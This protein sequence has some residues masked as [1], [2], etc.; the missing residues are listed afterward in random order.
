[1]QNTFTARYGVIKVQMGCFE[2]LVKLCCPLPHYNFPNA[3]GISI[4]LITYLRIFL[5]DLFKSPLEISK[6]LLGWFLNCSVHTEVTQ[7]GL[8]TSQHIR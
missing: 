7:Q 4:S 6:F 1:M 8:Y 3:K 2:L 5:S